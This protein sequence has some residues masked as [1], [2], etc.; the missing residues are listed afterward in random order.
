MQIKIPHT[1]GSIKLRKVHLLLP[2]SFFIERRV[3]VQGK[4]NTVNIITLIAVRRVQPFATKISPI[5]V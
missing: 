2:V 5:A 4:C 3:V 1:V